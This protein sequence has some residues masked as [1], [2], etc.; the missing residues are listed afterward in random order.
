MK[1]PGVP[2]ISWALAKSGLILFVLAVL[3][4]AF[5]FFVKNAAVP[6]LGL[7]LWLRST[8]V[9]TLW[10]E[11]YE[12]FYGL[13]AKWFFGFPSHVFFAPTRSRFHCA[14]M[15]SASRESFQFKDVESNVKYWE[16]FI[17]FGRSVK[18]LAARAELRLHH[19]HAT[20]LP[21]RTS[22]TFWRAF[23]VW[24]WEVMEVVVSWEKLI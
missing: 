6:F 11:L 17:I 16:S 18:I 14:K 2:W 13:E 8:H 24:S 21:L 10:E 7:R 15:C 12:I 23:L 5:E 22:W 9:R 20:W 4:L 19:Q 3:H 1:L